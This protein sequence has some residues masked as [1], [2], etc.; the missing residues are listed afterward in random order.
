MGLM[1][2]VFISY[3][4]V[5][6]DQDLA[7]FVEQ[8]L[9]E[10]GHDVFIDSQI[11]VGTRWASEIERQ[12]HAARFFVVLLSKDSIRSDMVRQEVDL[13]YKLSQQ[14]TNG[15]TILPIRVAFDGELPHDIGAYLDSI[16]YASWKPDDPYEAIGAQ[17]SAAIEKSTALPEQGKDHE[18][19]SSSSGVYDLF[20]VTEAI[21]A[22]LPGADP[23][24]LE[25]SRG[26]VKLDSP[27]YIQ[28][29]ADARILQ[30]IRLQGTTTVVKGARQMGK[31]SLLARAHAEAKQHHQKSC[32]LDFQLL[33]DAI[34]TNLDTLFRYLAR[35]I[36]RSLRISAGPDD[37]WDKFLGPKD[38]LTDFIA[39]AILSEA[40][41]P[42]VI[43]FDEVDRV[44]NFPYRD[45]F[46]ATIRGWHNLRATEDSWNRL[47]L[48][49][50]H[51]TEP[52]LWIQNVHQSPFN[53]GDAI[54]LDDFDAAQVAELNRK[55]REPLQTEGDVQE[56]MQ[57]VGGQ[58]YLVRQALYTLVTYR[59]GIPQLQKVAADET[60]PFADHLQRYIWLLQEHAELKGPLQQIL[61][62]GAC[63]EELHFQR[64]KAAGLVK[65]MTRHAVH[66]RCQ[67]YEMY[68]SRR[69]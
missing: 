14:E 41:A 53:V 26:A 22:P 52:Y 54:R 4:H 44:F 58:P 51:S 20:K 40:A 28:R 30:L 5:V 45:D 59:W 48:V 46:F 39:E 12:I 9:Q 11:L 21:G 34:L 47:N 6:P 55:H 7:H 29:E 10:R 8:Y 66:M 25:M 61:H 17:L 38:N 36:A 67:L 27:F 24:F 13:A 2:R 64:L 50:A 68:F 42:V 62:N 1:S 23:R 31:S 43:L 19:E 3:R 49:I 35:R 69:L 65:G 15:L 33:D 56:L 16:H 18:D 37:Y 57:L 32:Y 60:G 63:D